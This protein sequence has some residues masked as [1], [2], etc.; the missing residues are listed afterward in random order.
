MTRRSTSR[1]SAQ[2]HRQAALLRLTTRIVSAHTEDDIYHAM[3]DGLHDEAIG[4]SFLGAFIIDPKNGDRVLRASAGWPDAPE[5]WRV[6][7]GEGI[8][9]RAVEDGT[10]HYTPDVTRESRYLPSR[11]RG[12]E[13]DIPLRINGETIGVLVVESDDRD[14]FDE[15]DFEILEAAVAEPP[16]SRF[17]AR[18]PVRRCGRVGLGTDRSR[19]W[20]AASRA[21]PSQTR[22]GR[23]GGR[24][25]RSR[26]SRAA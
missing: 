14:A 3:V 2:A 11:V 26:A 5:N 15:E 23:R 1:R 21:E 16:S 22:H 9:E 4:Y 6:H 18:D 20:P 19:R 8:S 17:H 24:E 25:A 10:L 13:V 12:S 7:K